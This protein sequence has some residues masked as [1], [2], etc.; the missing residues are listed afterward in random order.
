MQAILL[1]FST[2]FVVIS[3]ITYIISI[4]KGK[5]K[6]HRMTRFILAFVLTLNF[7]SIFAA[8]GNRGALIFAGVI[9]LQGIIIFGLSLWRGMGGQ[10]IFDW[11]CFLIAIIGIVGW[12]LTGSPLVGLLF[13]ILADFSAYLPAFVKTWKYPQ[14]EEPWFYAFGVIAALLSLIAYKIEISSMFQ[15]YIAVSS[16]VMILF[17][18]NKRIR[19]K[20]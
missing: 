2:I 5:T 11:I 3:P 16:F 18:F 13:S 12:K 4:L 9:F 17:I 6:P 20:K 15:I 7:L 14:T 10:S 1:A 19:V 8:H